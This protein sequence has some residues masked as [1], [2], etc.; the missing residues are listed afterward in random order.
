MKKLISLTKRN[1]LVYMRDRSAVFFSLLSMLITLILMVVFLGE[2]NVESIVNLLGEFG[3]AR[4][5][6]ADRE[7]ALHLVQYWTL[8]GILV[9][10]AV[11]VTLTVIGTMVSDAYENR[12]ES[13][14]SA[15]VSKAV[16]AVAY[17]LSAIIIGFLFCMLTTVAGLAFVCFNGGEVLSAAAICKIM[18]FTFIN[19]SIFSVVMYL[20]ALCVKSSSAWSGIATLV[21][22]LVGFLGAV[23][24]P[25]GNLPEGVSAVLKCLPILHGASLM[26]GICCEEVLRQTFLDMPKQVVDS[27]EEYMGI[28][29]VMA[30]TVVSEQ[31][32][33]L[34]M[35]LCGIAALAAVIIF[36]RKKNISDR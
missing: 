33:I 5:V 15:P 35:V 27:Y 20:A 23:Y 6:E 2:M 30:D 28:S 32:S 1:M 17:I 25:M 24:V 16:V 29:I 11:T 8:A 3:G 14:Y 9:I 34:F 36:V 7:N 18:F 10:N 4:D 31:Y 19:V 12:L 22:T 21:G 13:F 26:R